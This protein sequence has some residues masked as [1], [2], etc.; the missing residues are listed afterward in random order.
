MPSKSQS[1]Q[2]KPILL[3]YISSVRFQKME[4]QGMKPNERKM[5][6]LPGFR[7][8]P[9]DQ[10]LLLYYLKPKVLSLPLPAG[11]I[12]EINFKKYDPWDLPGVGHGERYFFNLLEANYRGNK[13]HRF[14]S[15]VYWKVTGKDRSVR[16]SQSNRPIGT[17]RVLTFY[18][19]RLARGSQTNWIMHEYCL[20]ESN[21]IGTYK[22]SNA[23][24]EWTVCRIFEKNKCRGPKME[25]IRS[26]SCDRILIEDSHLP[27]FRSDFAAS[28]SCITYSDEVEQNS[29]CTSNP[30]K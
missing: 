14:T 4:R 5:R 17:K 6:L 7:F 1:T 29:T 8:D 12:P 28:S 13:M 3:A 20:T 22:K 15:S 2:H 9:T 24:N 25:T 19:G 27:F 23:T 21:S 30:T 16:T 11:V 18:I 26:S 10:E